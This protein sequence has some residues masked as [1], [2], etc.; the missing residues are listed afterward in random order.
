MNSVDGAYVGPLSSEE[1]TRQIDD[2][3][4]GNQMLIEKKLAELRRKDTPSKP[5]TR[6]V[7]NLMDALR[8]S[9]AAEASVRAEP[10]KSAVGEHPVPA[11]R[12]PPRRRTG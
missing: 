9:V 2:K 11:K 1:V 3:R 4:E 7:I 5:A 6:N 8:R 12:S 10:R